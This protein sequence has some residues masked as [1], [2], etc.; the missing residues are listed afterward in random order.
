MMDTRIVKGLVAL[1][2]LVYTT[3]LFINGRIG[4]GI[5]MLLVSAVLV[6]VLLRSTRLI[7]VFFYMRQQKMDKAI[8]WLDRI[9]PDRLWKKQQGYYYFLRGS[10]EVNSSSLSQSE[11]HFKKALSLGLRMNHDKAA[12]KLNLAVIAASKQRPKE[13]AILI[14]EAEKLD[15][16]GMLKNDIK[17]IKRQMKSPKVIRQRR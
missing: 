7:M 11:K 5:G 4:A 2:S 12:A 1:L 9:N 17:E 3:D 14:R 13:A 6:L 15:T 16:K 8:V 10:I